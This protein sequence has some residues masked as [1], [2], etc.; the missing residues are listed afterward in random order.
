MKCYNHEDKDAVG[1]CVSCKKGI[2]KDCAIEY[3][4]KLYCKD[5]IE[6][7]K[8]ITGKKFVRNKKK[9]ILGGVCAGIAD[10]F[11]IEPLVVRIIWLLLLFIPIFNVFLVVLYF[12]LW[13]VL[14]KE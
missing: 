4:E 5:C 1:I 13:I 9:Q 7:V 2:C 3:N 11:G 10:Y 8:R 12:F 14:P 6:K